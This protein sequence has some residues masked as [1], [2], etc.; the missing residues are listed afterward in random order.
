MLE[1]IKKILGTYKSATLFSVYSFINSGI[2][3]ILL[4]FIARY[5]SEAEYGQLN[6]YNIFVT[7]LGFCIALNSTGYISV[8]YFQSDK[9]K[10]SEYIKIILSITSAV[11]SISLFITLLFARNNSLLGIPLTYIVFAECVCV[12][13][14]LST[15][16][17]DIYRL[18]GK[19]K[20]YGLYSCLVVIARAVLTGLLLIYFVNNWTCF[21]I[22]QLSITIIAAIV[23]IIILK[24]KGYIATCKIVRSDIFKI[25]GFGIPL[26]PHS[27]SSWVRQGF[28]RY[29][30]N[31]YYP[32]SV[33][34]VYSLAFNVAN[35]IHIL[36]LAFN[37]YFSVFL[38]KKLSD[39]T[40]EAF[41][42]LKTQ[43]RQMVL[44][45][46]TITVIGTVLAYYFAP[47]LF[48]QYTLKLKVLAP[49]CF[50]SMFQSI[51][52]LFVNYLFYYEKTRQL[53]YISLSVSLI[54]VAL[55]IVLTKISVI[56]SA[57]ITL[58]SNIAIT[59]CIYI[60][61]RKLLKNHNLITV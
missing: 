53:M 5:L 29:I 61:S 4:L 8:S 37:S 2:N 55:S 40:V 18:E 31:I 7:L 24:N 14:V 54:H 45:F 60:Y 36:G 10:I 1:T 47:I 50:S 25:L 22:A 56:Y 17:L 33:V 26:I 19:I 44:F 46:A 28:D 16:L 35:I 12:L 23:A 39:N 48:P 21:P 43:T 52:Y 30:I 51:Y 11:F 57:Y 34:G 20:Q 9:Q 15:L 58:F 42:I 3:F 13:Q 59:L 32:L 38:Y 27:I 49:L 6:L 41:R